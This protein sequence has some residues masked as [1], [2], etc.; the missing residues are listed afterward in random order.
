MYDLSKITDWHGS[1]TLRRISR[2]YGRQAAAAFIDAPSRL[3]ERQAAF[4]KI[5]IELARQNDSE[6]IDVDFSDG[7]GRSWYFDRGCI[8]ISEHA[9]FIR[10]LVN[11]RVGVVSTITLGWRVRG[12]A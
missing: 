11:D 2:S 8:K 1:P 9:G 5:L 3:T 7:T 6:E 4:Y 10:P 12:V